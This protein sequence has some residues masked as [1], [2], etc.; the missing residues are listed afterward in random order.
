MFK[1]VLYSIYL[2]VFIIFALTGCV[3]LNSNDMVKINSPENDNLSIKGVWEIESCKNLD[4]NI[5]SKDHIK[6]LTKKRIYIG[7]NKLVVDEKEFTN[8]SYKLKI[9]DKNYEISYE[10]SITVDQL[11]INKDRVEVISASEKNNM[12]LDFFIVDDE[13][14]CIY[15][16]GLFLTV[17]KLDNVSED[18]KKDILE[19]KNDN[20][21]SSTKRYEDKGLYLTLKTPRM[22]LRN[23]EYSDEEYRT[24]WISYQDGKIN[25]VDSVDGIIFP[26]VSGMWSLDKKYIEKDGI[27]QEFFI[28]NQVNR[29]SKDEYKFT[30]NMSIYRNIKYIANDY[31]LTEEYNGNNFE[32]KFPIYNV[33]P[34]DNLQSDKGIVISDI[35]PESINKLYEEDYN[36]KLNTLSKDQFKGVDKSIDYGNF[37]LKREEGK[38]NL[39]G[40]VSPIHPNGDSYDYSLKIKTN[41]NLVNFDMLSIPW[42]ILRGEVPLMKD[43]YM[44][45]DGKLAVILIDNE[46]LVYNVLEGNRLEET[47]SQR[48]ELKSGET[49][50]MADWCGRD[51]VEFWGNTFKEFKKEVNKER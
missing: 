1:K 9:V 44:S 35:Y 21:T 24:L 20:Y 34:V 37:T 39:F 17:K 10:K 5:Y 30:S 8:V 32:N 3:N 45:P 43:A 31:I 22:Q 49:V 2:L 14:G 15:Y 29:E 36:E 11:Q 46:L 40:R 25:P 4:E 38:W 42:R 6:D 28:A 13:N 23:G 26:R 48:Y 47:P 41:E 50:I 18:I 16:Q 27:R 51:Y 33:L 12:I 19:K 7:E